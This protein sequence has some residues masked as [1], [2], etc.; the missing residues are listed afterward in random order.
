MI[1][2]L[3][4][5]QING[6]LETLPVDITFADDEGKVL[7]WNRQDKRIFPRPAAARGRDVIQCHS[8]KSAAKVAR[9]LEDF[10]AGRRDSLE[11]QITD[12]GR[13]IRVTN[14]AVRD[15]GGRYLGVME[16]EQDITDIK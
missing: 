14:I 15:P 4:A 2:E 8:E 10:A 12:N 7:Y 11:Y 9:L 5:D 6:I 13:I 16:I 1:E 3:N